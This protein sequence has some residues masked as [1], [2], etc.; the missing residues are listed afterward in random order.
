[1]EKVP[2]IGQLSTRVQVYRMDV[3]PNSVN[4]RIETPV[5]VCNTFAKRTDTSGTEVA[6]EAIVHV[7]RAVYTIRTRAG[8]TANEKLLLYDA[9]V[10]YNIEHVAPLGRRYLELKCVST[11][12]R[13]NP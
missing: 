9:G 10:E 7:S 6:G 8:V 4:E 5:I 11:G 1:M 13:Q 12:K 3:V 2:F